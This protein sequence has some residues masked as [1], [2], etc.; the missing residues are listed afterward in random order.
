M[1]WRWLEAC[2][3]ELEMGSYRDS[4]VGSLASLCCW[5]NM[6]MN[7]QHTP[8]VS[9]E[10]ITPVVV[11]ALSGMGVPPLCLSSPICFSLLGEQQQVT[12]CQQV[13]VTT[14]YDVQGHTRYEGVRDST[15]FGMPA[16]TRYQDVPDP[17]LYDIARNNDALSLLKINSKNL[18]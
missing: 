12:R 15:Q 5:P 13:N 18:N 3:V 14:K 2:R 1:G 10:R 4:S 11:T 9:G 6:F 8:N 16:R 17:I 7:P